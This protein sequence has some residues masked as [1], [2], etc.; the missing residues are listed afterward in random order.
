MRIILHAN[1]KQKELSTETFYKINRKKHKK[2]KKIIR[3][4]RQSIHIIKAKQYEFFKKVVNAI[5]ILKQ[6]WE[7]SR[8]V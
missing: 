3:E 7:A 4:K 8:Q 6:L 2:G 5:I 1:E